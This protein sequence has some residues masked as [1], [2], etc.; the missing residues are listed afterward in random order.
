[1]QEVFFFTFQVQ[2]IRL[3][4]LVPLQIKLDLNQY[5]L[6]RFKQLHG[7]LEKN[8]FTVGKPFQQNPGIILQELPL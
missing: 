5:L 2:I 4:Q 8:I 7:F 6:S 3:F 1:M